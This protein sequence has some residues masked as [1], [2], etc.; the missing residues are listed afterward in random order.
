MDSAGHL[1]VVVH[2]FHAR[3]R[4]YNL[5]KLWGDAG[6]WPL[7]VNVDSGINTI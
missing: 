5:E 2:V 1:D 6:Y 3:E 4:V 7:T